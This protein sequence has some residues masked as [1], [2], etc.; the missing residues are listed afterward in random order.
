MIQ[1][2]ELSKMIGA[3]STLK[4]SAKRKTN[5][6]RNPQ[7]VWYVTLAEACSPA[8]K[9]LLCTTPNYQI[10]ENSFIC[11]AKVRTMPRSDLGEAFRSWF[12]SWHRGTDQ[13][14]QQ[15]VLSKV[16]KYWHWIDPKSPE[17]SSVSCSV[18]ET[19][20]PHAVLLWMWGEQR[21]L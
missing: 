20:R 6:Q 17:I 12:T 9:H 13:T 3:W 2:C 11:S 16:L 8:F 1:K 15:T 7:K 5:D 18:Y 10:L 4:R 21:W 19:P 14:A